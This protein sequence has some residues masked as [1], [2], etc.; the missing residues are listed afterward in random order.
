MIIGISGDCE[1]ERM[2]LLVLRLM[3]RWLSVLVS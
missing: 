1:L 2:M 3:F